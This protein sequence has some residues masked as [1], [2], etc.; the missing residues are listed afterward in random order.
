MAVHTKT[1]KDQFFFLKNGKKCR[2]KENLSIIPGKNCGPLGGRI[3]ETMEYGATIYFVV[4]HSN[5]LPPEKETILARCPT[6]AKAKEAVR[7][8]TRTNTGR[9]R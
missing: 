3:I 5:V 7:Y 2:G 6:M 1:V 8:Y 9:K 4:A